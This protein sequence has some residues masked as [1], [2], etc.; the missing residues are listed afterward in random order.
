MTS[1]QQRWTLL[2]LVG[3]GFS[4]ACGG[5]KPTDTGDTAASSTD[6]G[7][8][9]TTDSGDSDHTGDSTPSGYYAEGGWPKYP[10]GGEV[11]ATG[12]AR[13]DVPEDFVFPDQYGE[14]VHLYDFCNQVVLLSFD[15]MWNGAAFP[16]AADLQ[17]LTR[18]HDAGAFMAIEMMAENQDS[19]PAVG[20]DVVAWADDNGL[21][22]PVLAVGG[23]DLLE[24]YADG[25][26]VGIPYRVLLG[27]GLVIVDPGGAIGDE[28]VEALISGG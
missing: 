2:S 24:S 18:S 19:D 7:Q 12:W 26:A 21:T 15:A 20:A 9:T 13:G 8:D 27:P 1:A 22:F 11:V 6:S 4:L 14:A 23:F 17:S 25:S 10:C 16:E 5:G 28:D 3:L